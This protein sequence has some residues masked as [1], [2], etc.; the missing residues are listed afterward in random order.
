MSIKQLKISSNSVLQLILKDNSLSSDTVDTRLLDLKYDLLSDTVLATILID[1]KVGQE[2]VNPDKK[3][4]EEKSSE[5]EMSCNSIAKLTPCKI[6]D[7]IQ[8]EL[9][10]YNNLLDFTIKQKSVIV[11]PKPLLVDDQ[12]EVDNLIASLGGRW[13]E[14]EENSYW[15]IPII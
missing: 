12:N 7:R 5:D 13:V 1:H 2:I 11:K 10:K 9:S 6:V 3:V 15:E 8:K 4:A 14:S